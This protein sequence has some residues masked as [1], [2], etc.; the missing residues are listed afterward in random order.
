MASVAPVAMTI[1]ETSKKRPSV[2]LEACIALLRSNPSLRDKSKRELAKEVQVN[3][4]Y[5]SDGTWNKAKQLVSE[6]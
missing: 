5:V 3:G 6:E 1:A 4:Q 2:A